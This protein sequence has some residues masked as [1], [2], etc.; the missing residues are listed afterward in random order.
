MP[1]LIF[2]SR[3]GLGSGVMELLQAASLDSRFRGNDNYVVIEPRRVYRAPALLSEPSPLLQKRMIS[4]KLLSFTRL[5]VSMK[6][7]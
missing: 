1:T 4:A 5:L 6:P 7:S 2:S 3:E